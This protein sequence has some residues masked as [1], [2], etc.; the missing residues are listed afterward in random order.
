MTWINARRT[1]IFG[2]ELLEI[3]HGFKEYN[4]YAN[5]GH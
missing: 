1:L 4:L 2:F 3:M 5:L